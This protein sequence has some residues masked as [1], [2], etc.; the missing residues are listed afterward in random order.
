MDYDLLTKKIK[1]PVILI[2]NGHGVNCAGKRSPDAMKH[3]WNSPL[4]FREYSWTRKCAQGIVDVLQALGQTAFLLVKE[5]EDI[6]LSTRVERVNAY[7]RKYGKDNVL[8][9]SIHNDAAGDGTTWRKS[10]GW[11]AYT[12]KGITV[13]DTLAAC[14]YDAAEATFAPP[15]KVRKYTEEPKYGRDYEEGLYILKNTYCAAVLTE[16][17]FQDNKEDVAYLKSDKG[18]GEIIDVHVQGI[19]NYICKNQ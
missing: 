17:F 7:C 4:Y 8:V 5:E 6:P 16:N 10:R 19:L 13:S 9:V 1:L 2:D 14:L 18:L 15:L 12:T 3:L 11:S